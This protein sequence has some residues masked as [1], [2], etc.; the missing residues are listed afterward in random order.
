MG[1]KMKQ[2]FDLYVC[3]A[4]HAQKGLSCAITSIEENALFWKNNKIADGWTVRIDGKSLGDYGFPGQMRA[5][6]V[7]KEDIN[8]KPIIIGVLSAEQLG[9]LHKALEEYEHKPDIVPVGTF[10]DVFYRDELNNCEDRRVTL[11]AALDSIYKRARTVLRDNPRMYKRMDG[12]LERI[13]E[14]CRATIDPVTLEDLD[15]DTD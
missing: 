12:A 15:H 2:Q 6:M 10:E 7:T 9:E 13:Y 11:E 5:G 4:Y 3:C 14:V 1:T 8:R